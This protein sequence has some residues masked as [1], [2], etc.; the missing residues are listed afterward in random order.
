MIKYTTTITFD[1][2][3]ELTDNELADLETAIL[4]QVSE[5]ADL[6]GED[7]GYHTYHQVINTTEGEEWT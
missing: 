1:V 3:R 7:V 4:T 5:P 6:D 2:D